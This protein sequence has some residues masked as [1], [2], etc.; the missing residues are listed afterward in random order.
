MMITQRKFGQ[1]PN[2]EPVT[3]FEL[4]SEAGFRATMLSYGATLQS[5]IFP[6]GTDVVLG[7]D[8]LAGYLGP[9]PYFG[10]IIGRVANRIGGARLNIAG[11]IYTLSANEGPNTLHGGQIGFDRANWRGRVD[12]DVLILSHISS[13]GDQGFPGA[14][15]TELRIS[16][17]QATLS[18][19]MKAATD[20]ATPVNLT[21]HSYFNL[22]GAEAGPCQDHR[23]E[24]LADSYAPTDDKNLPTGEIKSVDGTDYDYRVARMLSSQAPLDHNF[25]RR[26]NGRTHEM[27]KLAKLASDT[28]GKKVIIC[29]TQPCFQ[30]YTG[31]AIPVIKGKSGAVYGP[32]HGISIEPQGFIDSLNHSAFPDQIL[33]PGQTYHHRLRYTFRTE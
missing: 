2:G 1:M 27:K 23:L 21:H 19:E 20:K 4:S 3:A 5:L 14:L 17:S 16:F 26:D 12:D 24:I 18:I 25:I 32:Y 29:A 15:T 11:Q 10:A 33:Q 31:H 22:S 9:H 13:D 28:S 7:F 6:D 8:T 30:I